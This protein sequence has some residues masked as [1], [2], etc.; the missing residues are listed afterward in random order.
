MTSAIDTLGSAA[1]GY[2]PSAISNSTPI[3]KT[4]DPGLVQTA[5]ELAANAS[6]IASLG[7]SGTALQTYDAAGLLNSIAQA[8]SAPSTS[9]PVP[10]SGTDTQTE[11]QQL[12]DQSVVGTLP[13]D[14][15][16]SGIYSSA[17]TVQNF[18]GVNNSTDWATVLKSNPNL[19]GT[20]IADS[21]QQGIVG[22][23]AIA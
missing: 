3:V 4:A 13:S 14:P 8:G 11:G 9:I 7:N 1:L 23:L 5:V 20:V 6:A 22:L 16:T 18:S 2:S 17:G 10:S 19:A 15:G 12:I 21:Y